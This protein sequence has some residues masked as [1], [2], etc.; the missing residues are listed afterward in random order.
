MVFDSRVPELSLDAQYIFIF[1]GTLEVGTKSAP[2]P[3]KAT[4]TLHGARGT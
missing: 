4:I 2:F 3:G 1:G